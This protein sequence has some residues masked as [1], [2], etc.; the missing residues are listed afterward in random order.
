MRITESNGNA[1]NGISGCRV[2]VWAEIPSHPRELMG[3]LIIP[4]RGG[5]AY[6]EAHPRGD[7]GRRFADLCRM[8]TERETMM[9]LDDMQRREWEGQKQD[10]PC[11]FPEFLMCDACPVV[12]DCFSAARVVGYREGVNRFGME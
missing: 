4:T 6:C 1:R 9:H 10:M 3:E 12:N 2:R 7:Y 5:R 11:V 8:A